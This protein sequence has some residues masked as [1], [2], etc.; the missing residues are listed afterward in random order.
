MHNESGMKGGLELDTLSS[1][2][3][4]NPVAYSWLA[5]YD[6]C[7]GKVCRVFTSTF[8]INLL[9]FSALR[10]VKGGGGGCYVVMDEFWNSG[11]ETYTMD[12]K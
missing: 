4:T 10:V 2:C 11:T 1:Y 8:L 5:F 12:L 9:F 6:D 3:E 7:E